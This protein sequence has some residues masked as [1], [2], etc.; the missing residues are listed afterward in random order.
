MGCSAVPRTRRFDSAS[1][2]APGH[3]MRASGVEFASTSNCRLRR[4]VELVEPVELELEASNASD[5]IPLLRLTRWIVTLPV[6]K[7]PSRVPDNRR[8]PANAQLNPSG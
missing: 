6:K 5:S 2:C 4:N 3:S 1:K 7:P 8:L